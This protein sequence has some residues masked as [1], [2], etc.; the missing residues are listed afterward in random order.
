[1]MVGCYGGSPEAQMVSE[2]ARNGRKLVDAVMVGQD[3]Y[4]GCVTYVVM[5]VY[6]GPENIEPYATHEFHDWSISRNPYREGGMSA[7]HYMMTQREA[8]IDMRR[9]V[10]DLRANYAWVDPC[11]GRRL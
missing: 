5:S 10:A 1:M 3:P 9:R 2:L 4:E 8:T 7:G 11:T 6:M